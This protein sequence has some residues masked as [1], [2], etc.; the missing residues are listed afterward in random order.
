MDELKGLRDRWTNVW[1]D[2]K[3]E[4]LMVLKFDYY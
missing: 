4:G 3:I 1:V 2:H